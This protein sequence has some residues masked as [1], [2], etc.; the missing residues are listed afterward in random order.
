VTRW[1][2]VLLLAFV[3][4]G[5]RSSVDTSRALRYGVWVAVGVLLL[6]TV[7]NHAL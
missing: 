4:L 2:L 1:G 5:L 7:R 6:V 3:A